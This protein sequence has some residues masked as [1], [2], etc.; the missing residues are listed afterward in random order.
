VIRYS[1]SRPVRRFERIPGKRAEALDC[2]VYAFAARQ[3]APIVYD[4][5]EDALR[6][7]PPPPPPAVI[8]SEWMRRR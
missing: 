5:R 4:Q 8:R 3:A 1:R 7:M 2:L 6:L